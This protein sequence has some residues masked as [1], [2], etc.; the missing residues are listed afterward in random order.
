[1]KVGKRMTRPRKLVVDALSKNDKPMTA[2]EIYSKMKNKADLASVYRTLELMTKNN[3]VQE[4]EFGDGKKRYELVN[5]HE[6]HHHLVCQHCGNVEDV[7]MKEGELMEK[8]ANKSGFKI[9]RHNLEFFGLCQD[10][11]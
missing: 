11:Q 6:H 7:E 2:Q 3:L 1:M 4:Y 5:G 8:V 9:E 10:C